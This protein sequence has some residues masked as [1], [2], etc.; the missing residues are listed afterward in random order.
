MTIWV[1][2]MNKMRVALD[3]DDVL[4]KTTEMEIASEVNFYNERGLSTEENSYSVYRDG[5]LLD[6]LESYTLRVE[7]QRQ[8]LIGL[9][10]DYVDT[11]WL[12]H[13]LIDVLKGVNDI[14]Y[15]ILTARQSI[16]SVEP[17]VLEIERLGLH[18]EEVYV[19]NGLS[20][21]QVMI[22]EGIDVLVD[23]YFENIREVIR[24]KKKGILY[25]AFVD[26]AERHKVSYKA[27]TN[28]EVIEK[29]EKLK[30]EMYETSKD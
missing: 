17:L 16:K 12:N 28:E 18:I 24:L 29:L 20:K 21:A 25:T 15:V 6:N 14:E 2:L 8:R 9:L 11:K 5:K 22:N 13:D 30:Q 3:I 26:R 1:V 7:L 10:Y 27:K 19:Y 4:Y 23:D